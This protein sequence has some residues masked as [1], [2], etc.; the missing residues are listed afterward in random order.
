MARVFLLSLAVLVAGSA[1][2]ASA[3]QASWGK[4]GVSL[5]QYRKDSL[6]CGLKGHYTDISETQ[7]AKAFVSASRQLDTMT[8]A[9]SSPNVVSSNATG[10]NSTDAV[11]QM[12]RYADQQQRV[13]DSIRPDERFRN[14][15][16][17]LVSVTE[18]C[19]IARGY[20][21]FI[22]TGEQRHALTK[23]RPGSDERRAYLYSLASNPDV[24]ASQKTTQP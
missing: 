23:L 19:L 16:K 13:V 3:P 11:D 24:L 5:D 8:T 17:T 15:K 4:A 22:L 2:A 12:I 20:S 6:E 21:K 9:T 10:P 1:T 7:D 18:Q 14:I